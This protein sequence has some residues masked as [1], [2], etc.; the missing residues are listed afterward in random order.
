MQAKKKQSKP[1]RTT[2]NFNKVRAL[3]N[4]A[5]CL[6][7]AVEQIVHAIVHGEQGRPSWDTVSVGT[8]VYT[9]S[10]TGHV[11]VGMYH[12]AFDEVRMHAS[13]ISALAVLGIPY[14]EI[15]SCL[16]TMTDQSGEGVVL[17]GPKFNNG[18]SYVDARPVVFPIDAVYAAA[19]EY[20]FNRTG[21]V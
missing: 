14:R 7:P 4:Q 19:L 11:T 21:G 8:E 20:V 6:N 10:S 3:Q 12:P 13:Q 5:E 1:S 18:R 15:L 16:L 17:L 9:K 2:G